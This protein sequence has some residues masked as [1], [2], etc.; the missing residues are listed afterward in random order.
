IPRAPT[1]L[2]K[3]AAGVIATRP[4]TAPV[5]MPSMVGCLLKIQSKRAQQSP[6]V[7]AATCVITKALDARAP[8]PK[9]LPALKP[10]HPNHK[11][12]APRTAKG[13]LCGG[14][15]CDG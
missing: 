14:E 1:R 5:I 12:P 3:P 7:A 9:A 4:A 10:N 6:A 11:I 13:R 8:A 2:T 15:M